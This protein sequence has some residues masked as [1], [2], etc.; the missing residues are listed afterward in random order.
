MARPRR[1]RKRQSVLV[2]SLVEV[3]AIG[4]WGALLIYYWVNGEINLLIHPAYKWLTI[5]TGLILVGV[6]S[7]RLVLLVQGKETNSSG[8]V[9]SLPRTLGSFLLIGVAIA[10]FMMPLRVFAS[11]MALDREVRDFTTLNRPQPE[12][13]RSGAKSEERTVVDWVRTLNV[14]P[15]PD[16]Y[17]GQKVKV[18]GFVVYPGDLAENYLL[19]SRFVITCCAADVY[20]VGLPVKLSQSRKIFAPDT[21]L[22][23]EGE[24]MT[25]TFP[26]SDANSGSTTQSRKLVIQPNTITPIP[27]PENPYEY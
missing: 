19:V 21:W 27:E 24:M 14:Y 8:H 7:A 15:E 10:G 4:L 9:S 26:I 22:E 3:L 25:E 1:S 5:S 13:F 2:Q 6:S 16:A 23:I 20:P 17:T 11:A 18:Q 12:A